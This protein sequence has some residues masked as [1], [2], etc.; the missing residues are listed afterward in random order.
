LCDLLQRPLDRFRAQAALEEHPNQRDAENVVPAEP[1]AP[2]A[3]LSRTDRRS[4]SVKVALQELVQVKG[5][6]AHQPVGQRPA[7]NVEVA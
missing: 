2:L 5:P 6:D 7:T 3:D 4:N 1:A